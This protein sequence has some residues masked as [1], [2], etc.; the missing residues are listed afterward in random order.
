MSLPAGRTRS[1]STSERL[2]A[3]SSTSPD[4][5]PSPSQ[6]GLHRSVPDSRE[7]EARRARRLSKYH[8]SPSAHLTSGS[9]F[10][11]SSSETEIVHPKP[12]RKLSI[13][14]AIFAPA[15]FVYDGPSSRPPSRPSSRLESRPASRTGDMSAAAASGSSGPPSAYP[16]S[17]KRARRRSW[18]GGLTRRNSQTPDDIP[19]P[20]AWVAGH[21]D[22]A[23]YDVT[24]LLSGGKVAE[25]WDES[26]GGSMCW[27]PI[28]V[29]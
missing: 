27:R 18:L 24:A 15:S 19:A 2:S 23:A 9:G 26:G 29:L 25:I 16:G 11:C 21:A 28:L 4:A 10:P 3:Y 7:R 8:R 17:E 13:E 1:R 5:P 14:C 22:K 20:P 12:R 6:P